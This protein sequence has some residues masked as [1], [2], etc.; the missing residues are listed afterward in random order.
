MGSYI[1]PVYE[2]ITVGRNDQSKTYKKWLSFD[3]YQNNET[4]TQSKSNGIRGFYLSNRV[5]SE[6]DSW[7]YG[8]DKASSNAITHGSFSIAGRKVISL[9]M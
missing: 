5:H 8:L 7:I 4:K 2:I 6:R 9:Q 1:I 3:F